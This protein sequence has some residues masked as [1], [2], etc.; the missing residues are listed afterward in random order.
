MEQKQS[1]RRSTTYIQQ[2]RTIY[3]TTITTKYIG[4]NSYRVACVRLVHANWTGVKHI[5][6]HLSHRY[7]VHRIR[8]TGGLHCGY[9]SE[10]HANQYLFK[11]IK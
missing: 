1:N 7:E 11:N 4:S 6:D 9:K 3:T 5:F 2:G 8:G 10:E